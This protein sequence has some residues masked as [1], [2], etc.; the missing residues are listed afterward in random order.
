MRR[1]L[2]LGATSSIARAIADRLCSCGDSVFLAAR[3]SA[4]LERIAQDLSIRYGK[5]VGT[6]AF[7]ATDRKAASGVGEPS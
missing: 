7:D 6:D 4:E 5:S 1:V 3:S 2:V